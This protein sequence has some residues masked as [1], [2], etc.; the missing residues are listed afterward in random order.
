VRVVANNAVS[1]MT[2][3]APSVRAAKPPVLVYDA[4]VVSLRG[5]TAQ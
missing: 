2:P 5:W 3:R 4:D 1:Q